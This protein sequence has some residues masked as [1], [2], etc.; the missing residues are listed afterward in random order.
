ME[1]FAKAREF[2]EHRGYVRV[3]QKSIAALKLASIDDPIKDIIEGFAELP[4]CFT[5]QC[6]YGHFLCTPEQDLHNFE[7]IPLGF[8]GRATYRIAYI[9][10]CLENSRRGKALRQS[11]ARLPAIDPDYIQFGSA[12]WF[13]ER[14]VNSYALQ[15]EPKAHMLKDEAVLG[16]VEARHTQAVRDHFFGELRVLLAAELNENETG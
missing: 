9:A 6:C 10:F 4:H 1:S 8:S 5:L 12:D 2:V 7:P 13:W 14:W 11:L 3:R 16:P 15:V